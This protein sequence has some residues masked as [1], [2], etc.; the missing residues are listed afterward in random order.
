MSSKI[1]LSY[2]YDE[3]GA[4]SNLIKSLID[5][6]RNGLEDYSEEMEGFVA[7]Q[8][9]DKIH[10][11]SHKLKPSIKMFGLDEFH[12]IHSSIVENSR[13][14]ENII[15]IQKEFQRQ[16]ELIPSILDELESIYKGL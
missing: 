13:N 4:D 1:N 16:K 14:H 6:F 11:S 9:F 2:F 12:S 8:D 15:D 5:M 3:L 10:K 7:N